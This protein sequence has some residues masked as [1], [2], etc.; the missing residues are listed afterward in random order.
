MN[1]PLTPDARDQLMLAHEHGD[2]LRADAA[3][4]QMRGRRSSR[5]A[6]AAKLR[7]AADHLDPGPLALRGAL[8]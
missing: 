3:A 2:D 4:L 5:R 7:R 6:L 1:S 8:R